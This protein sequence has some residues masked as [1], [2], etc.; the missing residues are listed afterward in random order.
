MIL[1]SDD[2]NGNKTVAK[3]F[4][5]LCVAV[6]TFDMIGLEGKFSTVSFSLNLWTF[7][8]P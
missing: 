5:V 7:A 6:P 8:V 2:V 4:A 3:C 1:Y